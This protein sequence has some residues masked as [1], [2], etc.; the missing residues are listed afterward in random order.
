MT[1]QFQ[2]GDIVFVNPLSEDDRLF[3]SADD[4]TLVHQSPW[5]TIPVKGKL[6]PMVGEPSGVRNVT[7]NSVN[8][9]PAHVSVNGSK[10]AKS[11]VPKPNFTTF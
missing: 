7:V 6:L 5:R 4:L 9:T 1:Q 3:R 10:Y 11:T 8:W 2:V